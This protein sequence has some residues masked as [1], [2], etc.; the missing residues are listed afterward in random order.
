M[1]ENVKQSRDIFK[2]KITVV[3]VSR[4]STRELRENSS[5]ATFLDFDMQ[6]SNHMMY[7]VT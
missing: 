2:E 5:G 4:L 1:R 3:S 7:S 6:I